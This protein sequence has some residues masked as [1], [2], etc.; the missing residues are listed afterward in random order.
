MLQIKSGQ[1]PSCATSIVRVPHPFRTKERYIILLLS[2]IIFHTLTSRCY[3]QN[4]VSLPNRI[5]IE[6]PKDPLDGEMDLSDILTTERLVFLETNEECLIGSVD[7]TLAVGKKVFILSSIGYDRKL[8]VFSIESGEFLV[9]IGKKGKG[10]GEYLNLADFDVF[11]NKVYLLDG[12][13]KTIHIYNLSDEHIRSIRLDIFPR[14]L[15]VLEEDLIALDMLPYGTNDKERYGVIWVNSDGKIVKKSEML[16]KS[17]HEVG[18]IHSLVRSLNGG[19]Y[20]RT[21]TDSLKLFSATGEIQSCFIDFKAFAV[22]HKDIK[23]RNFRDVSANRNWI[24]DLKG[25]LKAY[26]LNSYLAT[27]SI[28]SFSFIFNEIGWTVYYDFDDYYYLAG[29]RNHSKQPLGITSM[30]PSCVYQDRFL[31]VVPADQFQHKL[32]HDIDLYREVRPSFIS[33]NKVENIIDNQDFGMNNPVIVITR[34]N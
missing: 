27:K 34:A 30:R 23:E 12:D 14:S 22:Q 6:L 5:E 13:G 3:G 28:L 11:D 10:P 26:Y 25:K 24:T 20:S 16:S 7:K 32:K 15:L 33:I 2:I 1:K 21:L 18:R 29:C 17:E 31:F 9:S 8:L 19:L 4:S